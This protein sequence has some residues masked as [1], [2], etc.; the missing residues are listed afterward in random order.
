VEARV[1]HLAELVA[2]AGK[3]GERVEA[4]LLRVE[5]AGDDDMIED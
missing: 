2:T 3:S 4:V 5:R 1:G